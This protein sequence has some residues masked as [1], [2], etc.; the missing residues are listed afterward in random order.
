MKKILLL[1]L[2]CLV[3]I[4]AA[5]C[6]KRGPAPKMEDIYDRLVEVI[7]GSHE[8]NVFLF[9]PGL[10]T[11]PRDDAEDKLI[12]RY[13]GMSD[14]SREYVTPYAKYA[15]VEEMQAAAA[16]V[17]GSEY[18]ESL[19]SSV[20]TGFV[21]TGVSGSIPARYMEDEK[22]L[23]QNAYVDPLVTG[24]RVYDYATMKIMKG[25]YDTRIRVSVQ[26]YSEKIPDE[27][28]TI[29]L[30]FVYENGNWYLDSPSC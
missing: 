8:V 12:H 27:W 2:L 14:P 18:R 24:T 26:S 23:Y 4:A 29:Y 13:Y 19:L 3:M 20:F 21:D 10:P 17:Y 30:N 15:M 1:L 9:G 11:Y 7:E 5:S 16:R 25:S 6:S 28:T 22:S